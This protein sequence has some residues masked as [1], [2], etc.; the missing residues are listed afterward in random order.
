MCISATG[1]GKS[2]LI[3]IPALACKDIVTVVVEPTNYL[4]FDMVRL[5][6]SYV[7]TKNLTLHQAFNISEK[8]VTSV[9]LNADTLRAAAQAGRNLFQ[10]FGPFVQGHQTIP[11]LWPSL[12]V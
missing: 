5:D 1:D 11:F 10:I 8:D 3:Y 4:G 9:V 2:A 6:M 7:M 12:Q